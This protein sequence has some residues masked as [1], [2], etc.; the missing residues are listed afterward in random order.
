M[1]S[2]EH[3]EEHA[4]AYLDARRDE[5]V[6]FACQLIAQPSINPPGPTGDERL[7]ASCIL[8]EMRRLGLEGATILAKRAERPNILWRLQ[9]NAPGPTLMYNGHMDTVPIGDG[10]L[11]E[12]P[13][14][15]PTIRNGRLYGLGASDMKSGIAAMVYAAAAVDAVSTSRSGDLLLVFN[16]DEEGQ[17]EYGSKYLVQERLVT[18]DVAL[19]SEPS[20][21]QRDLE[22]LN[23]VSRGTSCFKIRVY[24][25]PMHSSVSDIVGATNAGAKMACLLDQM[26][27]RLRFT[28]PPHLLCP[29]GVTINAGVFIRG[30]DRYGTLPAYAEFGTDI[31]TLPGMTL[32]GVRN[33]LEQF[34]DELRREDLSLRVEL[35]FA[36]PPRHWIEA[37]EVSAQEP[38]VNVL[39]SAAERVLGF[40]PKL[41]YCPGSTD[42]IE[43]QG[44]GHIPTIPAFGPGLLPLAHAPNEYVSIESI[45]QASKIYALAALEFLAG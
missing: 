8:A 26:V 4:L 27:K 15:E 36:D 19:I 28:H 24:G 16:A 10:S 33:D 5:I 18:A 45:I 11:W 39:L 35:E 30:G 1:T 6:D 23:L 21:I 37:T 38:F 3:I 32:S 25:T 34:L 13:P 9:G 14:L 12:T 17:L 44:R 31:R 40:V 42:A 41:G 29:Q 20:G 22:Y 2:G 43:F 7:V